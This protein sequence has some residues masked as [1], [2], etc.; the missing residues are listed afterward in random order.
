MD[1]RHVS[2]Q[3]LIPVFDNMSDQAWVFLGVAVTQLVVLLVA[4][5]GG[6]FKM[7][8]H[9]VEITQAKEA[10]E[11]AVTQTAATSNGF[12]KRVEE[13]LRSISEAVKETKEATKEN[14]DDLKALRSEAQ[15]DRQVV[16]RHLEDHLRSG[17]TD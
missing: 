7:R 6:Y 12:A 3:R 8:M 17:S 14:R 16:I 11:T 15:A 10:A 9:K 2:D 13:S 5:I 1:R 4:V